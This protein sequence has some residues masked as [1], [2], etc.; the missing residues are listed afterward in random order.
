MKKITYI[1][2]VF[3]MVLFTQCR[4]DNNSKNDEPNMV[5]ITFNLPT[6]NGK[7][8]F[9][10][11][12][13]NP[14]TQNAIIEWNHSGV[15]TIFLAVPDIVIH[16]PEYGTTFKNECAQLVPLTAICDGSSELEFTGTIDSRILQNGYAYTLYYFGNNGGEDIIDDY[17]KVIGKTMSFDGQDGT[18]EN[19]GDYHVA[20][21]N[22]AIYAKYDENNLAESYTISSSYPN[23]TS[24][25]GIALLDLEG[26]TTLGGS[27]AANSLTVKFNEDLNKYETITSD[28]KGIQL[29]NTTN[30]AF[31][32]LSPSAKGSILECGKGTY[33][34]Q[35]GLKANTVH[36]KFNTATNE[37][38]PL[39]WE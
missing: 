27:A 22:V 34:F 33:T 5:P 26:E 1:M 18:R 7:T 12:L 39:D 6:N 13:T 11:F 4:P 35:K 17:G 32:S 9:S 28:V 31:I 24:M 14:Y 2:L 21:I 16:S 37:I 20:C 29:D 3:V 30:S 15:E 19:L 10:D 36:Y 8:D 23:F 25:T 38:Q